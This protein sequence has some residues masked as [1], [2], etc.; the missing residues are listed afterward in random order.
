[1]FLATTADQ[2][3]WKKDESTLFLGGWCKL[4][5][6]KP[7]WEA[8]DHEVL[9]YHWDDRKRLY[10]DY[11]YLDKLYEDVLAQLSTILNR[12][13]GENHSV[14]YWRIIIGPW[15]YGF[16]GILY[17][18]YLSISS[19]EASGK[20]TGTVT[21]DYSYGYWTPRDFNEFSERFSNDAY[22]HYLY[23][24]I[25]ELSSR[26]KHEKRDC[27]GIPKESSQAQQSSHLVISAGKFLFNAYAKV[28]PDSFKRAV[29]ISTFF[30]IKDDLLLQ[31]SLGQCPFWVFPKAE[32]P[33]QE[34]DGN[35]RKG[36]CITHNNNFTKLLYHL[37]PEQFPQFY[38]ESYHL[39]KKKALKALPSKPNIIFT[40]N[41]HVHNDFF[42]IW[43]A[44]CSEHGSL[45]VGTQHGGFEGMGCWFSLEEHQNKIWDRYYSWGWESD[46]VKHIKPLPSGRLRAFNKI[47]PNKNG[48]ILMVNTA[49]MRYS[50][51]MQS[52]PVASSGQETYL[53]GLINFIHG[54]DNAPKELLTVRMY[55]LNLQ[56]FQKERFEEKFPDID[57]YTGKKSLY[58]QLQESRLFIGNNNGTAIL[59]ALVANVP[60][61]IFWNPYYW[62][63]RDSAIPYFD[64]LRQ[65]GILHDAPESAADLINK[66]YQDP[67]SWW[68]TPAI[69]KAKD[70]FCHEFARTSKDWLKEWKTELRQ[71]ESAWKPA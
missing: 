13:H 16:V 69:Q 32:I 31:L 28:I 6:H 70:E 29:F 64:E 24:R 17:D 48:R 19:A 33:A 22:N 44:S 52:M 36:I 4:Y 43:A 68:R 34:I 25:I 62:E 71:L 67:L 3:F 60:S 54:L 8:I 15:L 53:Q 27:S 21:A 47:R 58:K 11:L 45:F 26:L 10:S 18:R 50:Y 63:L 40:A 65:V 5:S 57:C 30:S 42:K 1:M 38:L 41:D 66:I 2:R 56:D 61:V 20:V 14:R 7:V 35:L 51:F 12:L 59:E 49:F 23:S 46:V 9:P 55:P 39:L 37:I